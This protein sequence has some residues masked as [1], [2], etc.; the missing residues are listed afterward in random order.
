MAANEFKLTPEQWKVTPEQWKDIKRTTVS[1]TIMNPIK[2]ADGLDWLGEEEKISEEEGYSPTALRCTEWDYAQGIRV[3]NN[4]RCSLQQRAAYSTVAADAYAAAFNQ[5]PELAEL[6]CALN[7]QR[8]FFENLLET[9]DYQSLHESTRGNVLESDT[10]AE[11]FIKAY[12]DLIE[13]DCT[14]EQ[15]DRSGVSRSGEDKQ[16]DHEISCLG[17]VNKAIK[18]AAEG[19]EEIEEAC[20]GLGLEPNSNT[21]QLEL[22]NIAK[23][24]QQVRNDRT[25]LNII[26]KAGKYRR[27]AQSKQR[28]KVTHGFDD[29]VGVNMGGDVGRVLPLELAKLCHPVFKKDAMRRLVE[30]QLMSREFRGI[31]PVGK[32]PIVV[33]VDE[34]GSMQG[35]P[36]ENA[37]AFTL[38]MC[39]IARKQ[40]RSI[41][42]YS[43]SNGSNTVRTAV[44]PGNWN[45]EYP[46]LIEWLRHFFTGGTTLDVPMRVVPD[47]WS[48]M[49]NKKWIKKGKTDMIIISDGIVDVPGNVKEY[50]LKW[51]K[52]NQVKTITIVIGTDP[53][54]I[55]EVSDEVYCVHSIDVDSDAVSSC[56]SI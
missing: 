56:F 1:T 17:A 35:N 9:P 14:E 44:T 37:K 39:W 26:N 46:G 12:S 2:D 55:K 31:E 33:C 13:E 6:P 22:Q 7:R 21:S 19:V 8:E 32:G 28:L 53:G 18:A 49:L 48:D 11:S 54:K 4:M 43:F 50:Y 27:V 23:S 51:K 5:S 38:A 52:E 40:N 42:L 20:R 34:S 30:R 45:K 29:V 10:A 15:R 47:Q 36:I 41:V 3:K 25:L 16:L 24:L